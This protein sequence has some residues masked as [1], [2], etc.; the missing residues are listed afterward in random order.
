M[1]G[2]QTGILLLHSIHSANEHWNVVKDEDDALLLVSIVATKTV[3]YYCVI[4][5][6]SIIKNKQR[7][8]AIPE[9]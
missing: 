7:Y 8:I 1:E 3:L 9:F 6:K 5:Y 2:S 4:L